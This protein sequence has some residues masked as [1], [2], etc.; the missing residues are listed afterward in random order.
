MKME[1]VKARTTWSIVPDCGGLIE[2]IAISLP[3]KVFDPG[4][5]H[6]EKILAA[7][8]NLLKAIPSSVSILAF[9][10]AFNEAAARGWIETQTECRYD[11]VVA[12]ARPLESAD[13]WAQDSILVQT[14]GNDLRI[15][16]PACDWPR[17]ILPRLLAEHLSVACHD[18]PLFLPGGDQIVGEGFRLIGHTS[19]LR[20]ASNKYGGDSTLLAADRRIGELDNRPVCYW[21]YRRQDL[22]EKTTVDTHKNKAGKNTADSNREG[23][24]DWQTANDLLGDLP[25]S[26]LRPDLVTTIER[27]ESHVDRYVSPTGLRHN[28][29]HLLLL[30]DPVAVAPEAISKAKREKRLLDASEHWLRDQG[31]EI[32]RNPVPCG[33]DVKNA[34]RPRLYNN[35]LLENAVREGNGKPIMWL[36]CF[37]ED[38]RFMEFDAEN[39]RIWKDLGFDPKQVFGWESLAHANGALR[40]A[41]KVIRR[42]A[43]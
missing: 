3:Q 42:Q 38:S 7:I 24:L 9:A 31:F 34:V 19:R 32:I 2:T 33:V 4:N 6:A 15:A 12:G 40:C 29:K 22:F 41:S 37:G 25:F 13:I 27:C 39:A 28:G 26:H 18:L 36:P 8:G 20:S 35:V 10:D 16:A 21:G 11:I 1:I 30:A 5:P 43:T 14:R 23:G 17:G